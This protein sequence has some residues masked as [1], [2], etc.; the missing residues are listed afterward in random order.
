M[1]CRRGIS[2]TKLARQ[3]NCS[4]E[5]LSRAENGQKTF[6]IDLLIDLAAYFHV[7]LDYLILGRETGSDAAV[8]E[9]LLEVVRQ[10]TQI[11]MKV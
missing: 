9:E 1:R 6:S 2:I 10:L 8:R 7:S 11:A 3:M 5:H 4:R